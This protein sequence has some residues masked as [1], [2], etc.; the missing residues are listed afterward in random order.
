MQTRRQHTGGGDF[1]WADGPVFRQAFFTTAMAYDRRERGP[2]P[3][4]NIYHCRDSVYV[5]ALVPGLRRGDIG[6]RIE[7]DDLV[8]EGYLARRKGRYYHEE[9]Y[10]GVFCRRIPL[11]VRVWPASEERL[12]NGILQMRFQRR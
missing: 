8:I 12:E 4:V 6:T 11:G 7:G 5:Q 3:L 1:F 2:F 9:R 10:S